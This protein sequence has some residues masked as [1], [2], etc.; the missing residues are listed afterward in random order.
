MVPPLQVLCED[1]S[2][3]Y[4]LPYLCQTLACKKVTVTPID[5]AM[6]HDKV[7]Y[8]LIALFPNSIARISAG[9]RLSI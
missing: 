1:H 7:L 3:T 4:L 2:G 8:V 9:L 5:R 6:K